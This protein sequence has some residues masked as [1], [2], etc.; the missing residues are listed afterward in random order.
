[1]AM[2][3]VLLDNL[4]GLFAGAD[5][6]R[7]IPGREGIGILHSLAS[8]FHVIHNGIVVGQM[9]VGAFCPARVRSMCPV[10]VL[11]V[12]HMAVITSLRCIPGIG[13]CIGYIYKKPECD[14]CRNNSNDD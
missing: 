11:R 7:D 12:H 2:D 4:L 6:N 10:L 14:N 1:M 9:A 13:G 8:L 3:A 5:R